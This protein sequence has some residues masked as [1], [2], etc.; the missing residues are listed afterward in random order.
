MTV[1]QRT[2]SSWPGIRALPAAITA[3]TALLLL[4][5]VP[6]AKGAAPQADKFVTDSTEL[7]FPG[8][9]QRVRDLR[10]GLALYQFYQ[11]DYFSAL[12]E[13]AVAA[14]QGG[15]QGH[16][17][18]PDLLAG[19]ISLSFGLDRKAE[20]VFEELLDAAGLDPQVRD[21]AWFYLTKLKFHRGEVAAALQAAGNI[22]EALPAQFGQEFHYMLAFL[23]AAGNDIDAARSEIDQLTE[24]PW[25]SYAWFNLALAY[26]RQGN[27]EQA[28]LALQQA[29]LPLAFDEESWSLRD[30]IYLA[31]GYLRL[32]KHDYAAASAAFSQVRDQG[33]WTE[34]ALLG[35]GWANFYLQDYSAAVQFWQ[36]LGASPLIGPVVQETY[37]AIPAVYEKTGASVQAAEGFERAAKHYEALLRQLDSTILDLGEE[38]LLSH[39]VSMIDKDLEGDV[40]ASWTAGDIDAR[41]QPRDPFFSHML[42]QQDFQTALQ[43]LSDLRRLLDNLRDWQQRMGAYDSMLETRQAAR[44]ARIK[45]T[46]ARQLNNPIKAVQQHQQRLRQLYENAVS[47]EDGRILLEGELREQWHLYDAAAKQFDLLSEQDHDHPDLDE[48]R[49]KLARIHGRLIWLSEEQYPVLKRKL[50]RQLAELEMGI[51]ENLHRQES[52]EQQ[53][54]HSAELQRRQTEVELMRVRIARQATLSEGLA[55]RLEKQLRER[56]VAELRVQQDNIRHYLLNARLA[57]AR[58]YDQF[59]QAP[60][61]DSAEEQPAGTPPPMTGEMDSAGEIPAEVQQ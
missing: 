50:D 24:A 15:I 56:A 2:L 7:A 49:L 20:R 10:Y 48:N 35:L 58:L 14:D 28:L 47:N 42:A 60:P 57:V 16:G 5:A 40:G 8:V 46:R 55:D 61:V 41:L 26:Q 32:S 43:Q 18:Y 3:F 34:Q 45:F 33:A 23:Y 9:Q 4:V 21:Q 36:L 6:Y 51:E 17:R 27:A 52:L 22:G 19:G 54:Q 12:R 25:L 44:Q 59:L 29:A 31:E 39:W 37:I 30:R 53:M 38:D 11:Q 1:V 13:L